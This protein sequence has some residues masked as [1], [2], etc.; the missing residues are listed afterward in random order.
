MMLPLAAQEA[1]LKGRADDAVGLWQQA[2]AD[3]DRIDRL[4]HSVECRLRLAAACISL[5]RL[6][7]AAAAVAPAIGRVAQFSGVGGVLLARSVLPALATADWGSRLAQDDQRTLR[8]WH[9]LVA[10]GAAA[11]RPRHPGPP[12]GSPRASSKCSNASRPAT[13]TSSSP[14]RS[15][16]ART[17]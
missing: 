16:S 6:D 8:G 14:A 5:G 1:W 10:A 7:A 13:A 3:E 11:P 15:T 4:G 2:L 17:P 9:A 12:K